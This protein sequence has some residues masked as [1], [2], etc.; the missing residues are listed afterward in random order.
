MYT[1][2][3]GLVI[4]P[5]T[6]IPSLKPHRSEG[7]RPSAKRLE[8]EVK[9]RMPE[10]TLMGIVARTAYWVEWWRRF[11]PPSGHDPKLKDRS[12]GTC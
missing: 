6:G 8:Q 2:N 3:E 10:R 12:A 5:E 11:G 9:A 4:D 7:Q 1:D